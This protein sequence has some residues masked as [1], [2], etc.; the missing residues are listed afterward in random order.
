MS[1]ASQ[2]DVGIYDE[3]NRERNVIRTGIVLRNCEIQVPSQG[4][5][6]G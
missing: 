6:M 2:V 4:N 1:L 3:S 5:K